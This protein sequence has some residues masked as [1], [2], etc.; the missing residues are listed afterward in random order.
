MGR[1]WWLAGLLLASSTCLG[2]CIPSAGSRLLGGRVWKLRGGEAE[3]RK[4]L[5]S[6]TSIK[7][8]SYVDRRT[9]VSLPL[10]A[11]VGELKRMIQ[12]KCPG[13]PPAEMQRLF[14]G[15]DLLADD[16]AAIGDIMDAPESKLQLLLDM[17]PPVDPEAFDPAT[18]VPS[19]REAQLEAYCSNLVAMQ[20][21]QA[22]IQR[23]MAG[24]Q[25]PF[26]FAE[27][28]EEEMSCSVSMKAGY[29]R[30][31]R[32]FRA[33]EKSTSGPEPPD[34]SIEV[35][36]MGPLHELFRPLAK[37]LDIEWG[38]S[39]R[40]GFFL[41]LCARYGVGGSTRAFLSRLLV[42]LV[43]FYQT[44]WAKVLR[45]FA[46]NV[47]P[48]IPG[49]AETIEALLPAPEQLLIKFDEDAYIERLYGKGGPVFHPEFVAAFGDDAE[50]SASDE[51]WTSSELEIEEE[52]EEDNSSQTDEEIDS[53][54]E[55]DDIDFDDEQ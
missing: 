45:K 44:R 3:E 5:V 27:D 9:D 8:S 11:T 41:F 16:D 2:D 25:S 24:D 53:E 36:A 33:T 17:P 35:K 28:E 54:E 34:P 52:E 49:L 37:Q 14:R 4:V 19:G 6:V 32:H 29:D 23:A 40:M 26:R 12:Q 18:V 21:M 46:W 15:V 7:I 42:P 47:V 48:V 1:K 43:F 39:V 13:R 22:A 31:L 10:S 20:E 38:N 55:S 30:L 50:D 51:D